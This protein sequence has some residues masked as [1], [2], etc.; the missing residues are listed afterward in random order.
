MEK[1]LKASGGRRS[2]PVIIEG[3]M[4]NVGYGGT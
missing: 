3:G 4:V 1:M 2:V